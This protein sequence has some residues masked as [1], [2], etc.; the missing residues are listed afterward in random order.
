LDY[1][2]YIFY[3]KKGERIFFDDGK[4]SAKVTK[5]T[6]TKIEVEVIV[7]GVLKKH[8]GMN[9]PD[10]KLAVRSMTDK[11]IEDVWF[12]VKNHV[13]YIALSF[14][15]KQLMFFDSLFDQDYEKQLGSI[16]LNQ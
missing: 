14:V 2:S 9:V 11:D 1:Q 3:K 12:G 15:R 8:K 13:D 6:G 5:V 10:T 7:G 4:L 16:L